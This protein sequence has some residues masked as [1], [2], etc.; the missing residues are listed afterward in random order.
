MSQQESDKG[1]VQRIMRDTGGINTK[2]PKKSNILC[3]DSAS[4]HQQKTMFYLER[5]EVA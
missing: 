5:E 3:T 2:H 1:S 4:G